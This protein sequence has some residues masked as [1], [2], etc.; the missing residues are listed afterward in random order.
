M[1]WAAKDAPRTRL[2]PGRYLGVFAVSENRQS[3]AFLSAASTGRR[4]RLLRRPRPHDQVIVWR[5]KTPLSLS[6]R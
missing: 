3:A 5:D 2:H 4:L 1:R 6:V